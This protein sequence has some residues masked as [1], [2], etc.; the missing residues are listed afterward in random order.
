MMK[1]IFTNSHSRRRAFVSVDVFFFFGGW[2]ERSG[3]EGGGRERRE[4]QLLIEAMKK[5][6]ERTAFERRCSVVNTSGWW[7]RRTQSLTGWADQKK[8]KPQVS[9]TDL[10]AP[11]LSNNTAEPPPIFKMPRQPSSSQK[12]SS[13]C[14]RTDE[15]SAEHCRR[16][17]AAREFVGLVGRCS[18]EKGTTHAIVYSQRSRVG[19][20][21]FSRL[22]ATRQDAP[23]LSPTF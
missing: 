18:R 23:P 10:S 15:G 14:R 12:P 5:R 1:E 6:R 4:D 7:E 22:R 3:K 17:R 20:Y 9:Y 8:K 13:S 16:P 2:W 19:I 11:Q 21:G